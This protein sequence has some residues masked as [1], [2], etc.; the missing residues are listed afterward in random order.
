MT[1]LATTIKAIDAALVTKYSGISIDTGSPSVVTPVT[2]FMEDPDPEEYPERVYPSIAL[3]LLSTV[4][5][6]FAIVESDDVDDSEE[7]SYND[8]VVPPVRTMRKKPLPHRVMYSID[9]WHKA[10][11]S[12]SRDLVAE[13]LLYLTDPRGYLTVQNIDGTAI[14]LWMFWDGGITA[15]EERSIDEIIYHKTLTVSIL[16]YLART[17]V[18]TTT[19]TKV[20]TEL[21]FEVQSRHFYLGAGGVIQIDDSKNVKDVEFRITDTDIEVIP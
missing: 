9:T 20:A 17:A 16:A 13:A 19:D 7:I 2:V 18:D 14:D 1:S 10:R 5:D 12:E 3:K 4:P 15:A 21:D 11:A 6:Y 8:L